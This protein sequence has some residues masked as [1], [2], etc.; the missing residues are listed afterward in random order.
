MRRGFNPNRDKL[1]ETSDFFHQV[2]IP[3]H[4]PDQEGYFK[5]SLTIFK[6]CFQSLIKT[7]HSKTFFTIIN[8]GSCKEVKSCLDAL[9]SAGKIHEV[10]H[11]AGI[12][13]LNSILKGITGHKF[14]FIT[15]SDADVLFINNWQAATY[16]VFREFTKAGVVGL[17]PQ[18]KQFEYNCGNILFDNF[19]SKRMIFTDVQDKNALQKFYSSLGWS[20][21]YN[22]DYLKKNLAVTSRRC[23]AIVGNGHYVATYRAGIFSE[24]PRYFSAKMGAGTEDYLDK[25]PLEYG[26]WKLTT[27]KN[28]AF[29]MGNV[30][31]EWMEKVIRNLQDKE[32]IEDDLQGFFRYEKLKKISGIENLIKNKAFPKIFKVPLLKKMFYRYKDLP[33]EMVKS[34]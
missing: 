32:K 31:E 2:V 11:T 7:C 20:D 6:Q 1:L 10:I 23:R 28:Y 19:F 18:F 14:D 3:L 8:N 13:K 22:P 29:H 21:D 15:I 5:E 30:Y 17:T 16:E 4:I 27:E 9:L 24:L 25:I 12:G 26:M 33:E 34:F